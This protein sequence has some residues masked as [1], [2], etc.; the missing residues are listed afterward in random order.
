MYYTN[1]LIETLGTEFLTVKIS[2]VGS[3]CWNPGISTLNYTSI[4]AGHTAFWGHFLTVLKY[5]TQ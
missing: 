4:H 2:F 3:E 5:E 1:K